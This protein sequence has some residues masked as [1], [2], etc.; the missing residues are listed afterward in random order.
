MAPLGR[1]EDFNKLL[2][3]LYDGMFKYASTYLLQHVLDSI[4]PNNVVAAEDF[5]TELASKVGAVVTTVK[6]LV[7]DLGGLG[8]HF[9]AFMKQH[10]LFIRKLV[11]HSAQLVRIAPAWPGMYAWRN[12][13]ANLINL[14]EYYHNLNTT[15]DPF[16]HNN[17]W[18][19]WLATMLAGTWTGLKLEYDV[20][21]SLAGALFAHLRDMSDQELCSELD[22]H[23]MDELVRF[24]HVVHAHVVSRPDDRD[25]TLS[26][27]TGKI[28]KCLARVRPSFGK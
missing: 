2:R 27:L 9:N 4:P 16:F 18:A 6:M 3:D 22:G 14:M 10:W 17:R 1:D 5:V 19:W 21:V 23:D 13:H 26:D 8:V 12:F 20:R 28:A 24:H 7:H 11:Y 25:A 15:N